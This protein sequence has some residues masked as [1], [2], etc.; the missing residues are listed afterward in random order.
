MPGKVRRAASKS[1]VRKLKAEQRE[2]RLIHC[3][4]KGKLHSG[5]V[6]YSRKIRLKKKSP[7]IWEVAAELEGCESFCCDP[8]FKKSQPGSFLFR[9]EKG[10]SD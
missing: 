1:Q 10:T 5:R 4:Q 6:V 9:G 3:S 2:L 8:Y 7:H